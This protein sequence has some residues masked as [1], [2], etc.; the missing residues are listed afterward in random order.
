MPRRTKR[1]NGKRGGMFSAKK[2][3]PRSLSRPP[4]QTFIERMQSYN[5]CDISNKSQD[6]ACGVY[7]FDCNNQMQKELIEIFTK[8][9]TKQ[10]HFFYEIFPWKSKCKEN[11]HMFVALRQDPRTQDLVIC[12]WCSVRFQDLPATDGTMHKTAYIVEV[13]VRRKKTEGAVD[14]SYRGMGIKLLQKIIEYSSAHGATMLYLM[15]SNE[16]VKGLYMSSLQMSEV[17][18]TS[19]L[20]KSLSDAITV[21]M[22]IDVIGLKRANEIADDKRIF[23]ES[24]SGLPERIRRH[25]IKKTEAMQ[26]DDKV[27]ILGEIELMME[28]GVSEEKL[29]EYINEL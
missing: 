29:V 28:E 9:A 20:V 7:H 25:F 23:K 14:E 8:I 4:R 19:Y 3:P 13:S 18:E 27:A 22:M 6:V 5:V 15:P 17:P 26:L 2:S 16:T 11:W 12:A 24:L 10:R 21:P 1:R